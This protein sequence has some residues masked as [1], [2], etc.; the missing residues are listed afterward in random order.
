MRDPGLA[1]SSPSD[2]SITELLIAWNAGDQSALDRL[3]PIVNDELRRLARRHMQGERDGH[4]LQTT[5]LVNEAYLRLV[6]LG[7]L[8]WQDRTHFFSMT[9]RLMRRVLVDHARAHRSQKR[10]GG[11]PH[12]PVEDAVLRAPERGPDLVALD[13]A[14]EALAAVDPRKTQVIELRFFGG[15]DVAETAD[16]LGVSVET[17]AR[18]WRVAKVWLLRELSGRSPELS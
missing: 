5:A 6:E 9:A 11:Q 4:T 7:R 13:E 16:V 15:F 14:L 2:N 17:V 3:L 1:G 12:V 18:D 8:R 10:G